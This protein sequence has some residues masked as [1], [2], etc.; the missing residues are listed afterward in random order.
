MHFI[1]TVK[2]SY[3]LLRAGIEHLTVAERYGDDFRTLRRFTSQFFN[4]RDNTLMLPI[5]QNEI[6]ILLRK[7][8]KEPHAFEDHM[9]RCV[10][11]D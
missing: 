6:H 3:E 10:G 5:L 11:L 9:D 1:L 4:S 8:L 2:V 7:L